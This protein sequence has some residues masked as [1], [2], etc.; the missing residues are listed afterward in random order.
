M[1]TK[2]TAGGTI[3]VVSAASMLLKAPAFAGILNSSMSN[4]LMPAGFT[5]YANTV[6]QSVKEPVKRF[7]IAFALNSARFKSI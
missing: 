3:T 1:G 6:N 2:G 5:P 4:R 7:A